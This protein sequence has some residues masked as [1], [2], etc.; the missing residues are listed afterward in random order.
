MVTN[1]MELNTTQEAT[2]CLA[3]LQFP[4]ILWNPKVHY[5]VHKSHPF[6]PILSQADPV[7]MVIDKKIPQKKTYIC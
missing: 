7:H 1:S 5:H 6:A 3:A 4:C 2:S